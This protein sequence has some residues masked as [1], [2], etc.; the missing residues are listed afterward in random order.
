MVKLWKC[1]GNIAA[2][3]YRLRMLLFYIS[4][5]PSSKKRFFFLFWS[6]PFSPSYPIQPPSLPSF[7]LL[8]FSLDPLSSFFPSPYPLI[9]LWPLF[10]L[11]SLYI[12]WLLKVDGQGYFSSQMVK[13]DMASGVS[14]QWTLHLYT[15]GEIYPGETEQTADPQSF[16][17]SFS[18]KDTNFVGLLY[19]SQ[20]LTVAQ[21]A[22][23]RIY[24]QM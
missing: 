23:Q 11:Y 4:L 17:Y 21:H 7:T 20:K 14:G 19:Y 6:P 18:K 5:F 3:L 24:V 9:P 12:I 22:R 8:K 13:G 2:T 16:I 10:L 15:Q 1:S